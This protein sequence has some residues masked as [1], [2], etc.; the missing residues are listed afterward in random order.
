[1]VCGWQDIVFY[2]PRTGE[3]F[4]AID[5]NCPLVAVDCL[6]TPKNMFANIQRTT[7]PAQLVYDIHVR[8]Q[9]RPLFERNTV[10]LLAGHEQHDGIQNSV[11]RFASVIVLHASSFMFCVSSMQ[12]GCLCSYPPTDFG[13]ANE[14]EQTI[15]KE[16]KNAFRRWRRTYSAGTTF[17]PD[18]STVLETIL[19]FLE[20][21]KLDGG[22]M[23]DQS[24]TM[25]G[26]YL[27]RDLSRLCNQNDTSY[28][29]LAYDRRET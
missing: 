3:A 7:S 21:W 16:L 15:T 17:Q 26:T 1:M 11:L 4:S 19:P 25:H 23:A 10:D 13:Y 8:D 2:C 14:I 12:N 27:T 9:W 29:A 6:V 22:P 24:A 18:V 5:P 28:P 20:Q